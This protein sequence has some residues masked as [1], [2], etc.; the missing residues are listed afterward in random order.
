[1]GYTILLLNGILLLYLVQPYIE[2]MDILLG[3]TN[4]NLN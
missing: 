1:M 3:F 4:L 2:S